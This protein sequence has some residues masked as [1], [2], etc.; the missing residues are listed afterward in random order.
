MG[1]GRAANMA[2]TLLHPW[3]STAYDVVVVLVHVVKPQGGCTSLLAGE[4][5]S[6]AV[7]GPPPLGVEVVTGPG[8]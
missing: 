2:L 4:A 6:T 8:T 7:Q 3:Q 5:V 1:H